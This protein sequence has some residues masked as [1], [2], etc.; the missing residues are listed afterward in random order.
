VVFSW[1]LVREGIVLS[2]L[3]VGKVIFSSLPVG[4]FSNLVGGTGVG[5]VLVVGLE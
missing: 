4:V 3:L 1:L 5:G 2:I